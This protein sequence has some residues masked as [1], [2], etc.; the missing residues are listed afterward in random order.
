MRKT[1]LFFA[2][3]IMALGANAKDVQKDARGAKAHVVMCKNNAADVYVISSGHH[4]P[5]AK[6][7]AGP[8]Y[9]QDFLSGLPASWSVGVD[10][11]VNGTWKWFPNGQQSGSQYAI[12]AIATTNGFMIYDSDSIG[13]ANPGKNPVGWMKSEVINCSSHATVAITFD[14]YFRSFNDS[15]FVDVSN[16]GS[17]WTRYSV[18]PNNSLNGNEYVPTNPYNVFI[19]ATAVAGGHSTVYVRFYYYGPVDGGYSWQVDNLALAELQAHN[20]I[21]HSSFL[22]SNGVGNFGATTV[23]TVPLTFVDSI[24]PITMLDNI[25][26]NT[27]SNATTYAHIYRNNTLVYSD[28]VTSVLPVSALDSIVEFRPYKPDAVGSYVV[29]YNVS[30]AGNANTTQINDTVLF[31]VTDTLWAQNTSGPTAYYYVHEP[32]PSES[33]F[34]IGTRFDVPAGASDTLTAISVAFDA[35]TTTGVPLQVQIY[36]LNDPNTGD[37]TPVYATLV[38]SLSSGEVSTNSSVVYAT[39]PMDLATNYPVLSQGTWAAEVAPVNVPASASIK[40]LASP[41][42][43]AINFVDY[44]GRA[45]TSLNDGGFSFC[46]PPQPATG[47]SSVPLVRMHF[48]VQMG[49]LKLEGVAAGTNIGAVY[50]NPANNTVNMS[51]SLATDANVNVSIMNAV[52]QIISTQSYGRVNAGVKKTATFSTS[53]LANGVYFYCIDVDGVRT[54][55][56]FVVSH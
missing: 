47:L 10:G 4:Q 26:A 21:T 13:T 39:F 27:E 8:F 29:A 53:G 40:V 6:G 35:G 14:E 51:F 12:G 44:I 46:S 45:D 37:W 23:A 7:T 11:S 25:G 32:A 31:D 20:V 33:S 55:N 22:Y 1:L 9:T 17:N 30:V 5:A 36:K 48:G 54:T 41:P 18:S 34:Y 38:H 43:P 15:C 16:D 56:R 42:S 28:T 2:A 3:G 19:N 50:P 49:V 52:G 24:A